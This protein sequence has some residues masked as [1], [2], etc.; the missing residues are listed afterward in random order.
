MPDVFIS[1]AK[2]DAE[3]ARQLADDFR[4]MGLAVWWD[5]SLYASQNYHDTI[6]EALHVS[7]VVVAIWSPNAMKSKWVRDEAD[8]AHETGKLIPKGNIP[9]GMG[10]VQV[11][12]I[13]DT[14]AIMDAFKRYSLR[15]DA[16]A[17][18]SLSGINI[19]EL[20]DCDDL[21]PDEPRT[22]SAF[23]K[24]KLELDSSQRTLEDLFTLRF[25]LMKV[26]QALPTYQDHSSILQALSM[27]SPTRAAELLAQSRFVWKQI[28]LRHSLEGITR[29]IKASIGFRADVI[30]SR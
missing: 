8:R 17:V 22:R 7:R 30:A 25:H 26:I 29:K 16:S 14:K 1:Y 6:L 2:A 28:T 27:E 19:H 3:Y 10:Q 13:H 23:Y 20:A 5:D 12:E 4:A 15:T 21:I 9:L 18:C 24:A 11:A